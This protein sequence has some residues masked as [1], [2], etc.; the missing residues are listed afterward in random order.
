VQQKD[1]ASGPAV[2]GR[3]GAGKGEMVR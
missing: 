3:Q 1:T 2:S